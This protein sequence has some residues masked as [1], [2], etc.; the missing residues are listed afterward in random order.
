MTHQR[1]GPL[2]NEEFLEFQDTQPLGPVKK[3]ALQK[4]MAMTRL[5]CQLPLL[6]GE[7]MERPADYTAWFVGNW[8][9]EL[10]ARGSLGPLK[11]AFLEATEPQ[12]VA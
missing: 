8:K 9:R 11:G 6:L 1:S 12:G 10:A 3:Q 4:L 5:C 2:E 7:T